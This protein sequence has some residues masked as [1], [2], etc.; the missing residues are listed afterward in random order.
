MTLADEPVRRQQALDELSTNP[1]VV[2]GE[3]EG[4]YLPIIARSDD[5]RAGRKR[6]WGLADTPGVVN[7]ELVSVNV[8]EEVSDEA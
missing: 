3:L 2:L 5:S 1:H 7:V 6:V 4:R 8:A